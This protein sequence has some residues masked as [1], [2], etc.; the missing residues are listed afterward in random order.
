MTYRIWSYQNSSDRALTN[1][2]DKVLG[3]RGELPQG[4]YILCPF[5]FL[6]EDDAIT[7]EGW[8]LYNEGYIERAK[9]LILNGQTDYYNTIQRMPYNRLKEYIKVLHK[10][11]KS[12]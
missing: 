4:L 5:D 2:A 8:K 10:F 7:I 1:T 12:E 6:S 11:S 9:R 3:N